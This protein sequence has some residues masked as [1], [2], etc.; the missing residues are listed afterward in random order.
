[1]P[2]CVMHCPRPSDAL[3]RAGV[4]VV[5]TVAALMGAIALLEDILPWLLAAT[6][7]AIAGSI[8]VGVL[9][10]RAHGRV[11]TGIHVRLQPSRADYLAAREQ[12]AIDAAQR[13]AIEASAV[14]PGVVLSSLLDDA[15]ERPR[16]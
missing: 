5:V 14:V 2:R 3:V 12:V 10:V 13:R 9:V 4:I 6:G 7:L 1:M 16:R 15:R 8:G 11:P